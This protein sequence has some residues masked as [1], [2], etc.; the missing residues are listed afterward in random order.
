ML[1]FLYAT[2]S[3]HFLNTFFWSLS[4]SFCFFLFPFFATAFRG[5]AATAFRGTLKVLSWRYPSIEFCLSS[6][7]IS[8]FL[9]L[10]SFLLLI[11]Y[12]YIINILFI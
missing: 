10:S 4:F 12:I 9:F 11:I 6:L 1:Q 2:L 3:L 7:Y 5:S 8:L